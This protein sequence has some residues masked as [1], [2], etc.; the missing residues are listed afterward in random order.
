[1]QKKFK[2]HQNIVQIDHTNLIILNQIVIYW[3]VVPDTNNK[4]VMV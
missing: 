1:M 4:G 3:Y 2:I